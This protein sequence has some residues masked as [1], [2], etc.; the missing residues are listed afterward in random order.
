MLDFRINTFLSVC[1]HMSYTKAAEEL[2]ITQ[3]AVSQHIHCLEMD[4]QTKLFRYAGKKLSL[5]DAGSLLLNTAITMK[6]DD[7]HLR[8]QLHQLQAG[9]SSL[10]F[11]VT[12]TVGEFLIPH[13]IAAY[14]KNH[15]NTSVKMIVSNTQDLLAKINQGEI[16]FALVEGFFNKSE[17]DYLVY[18]KEPFIAV[19]ASDYQ[20]KKPVH[21]I[22]DLLEER[23]LLREAGS[24]TRG[25]LERYLESCNL[26][27]GDFSNTAQISSI[28]ALLSLVREGCGITFL[29]E[30]AAMEDLESGRMQRI[31]LH[32]FRITH[33]ITFLWR[34]QSIFKDYYENLFQE[35]SATKDQTSDSNTDY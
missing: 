33:D 4:Y 24:G 5:T 26:T 14:L 21:C 16:D 7:V 6:H 29:Y 19:T 20:F 31:P 9:K 12:L 3:P 32:D 11:G 25:V 13:H 10:T 30:A 2:H 23:I 1:R 27:V 22:E 8:D 18:A 15:P 17:Y 34:K 28:R 35:L